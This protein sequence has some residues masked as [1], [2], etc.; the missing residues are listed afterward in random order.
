MPLKHFRQAKTNG[1][2]ECELLIIPEKCSLFCQPLDTTFHRQLK[3]LARRTI[4][5]YNVF[6]DSEGAHKA[7][8]ITTR[9][10]ILKLQII[11]APLA[12]W[13][14]GIKTG[15]DFKNNVQQYNNLK[16]I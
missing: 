6:V 10:G 14:D 13:T 11:I 4:N 12:I 16:S 7:D 9:I 15:F 2:P 1:R 3:N 5:Y 8:R